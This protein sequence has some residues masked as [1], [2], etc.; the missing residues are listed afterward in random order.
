VYPAAKPRHDERRWRFPS[1]A[2]IWFTHCEREPD[3]GRFDGHEYQLIAFDE[4]THFTEKQYSTI[5]A[6]LRGPADLPKY[7]RGTTNPGGPGHDWVFRRW[8][9]WLNPESPVHAA[10][11]AKLWYMPGGDAGGWCEPGATST[12]HEG[13]VVRARSRVFIPARLD[14]NPFIGDEYRAELLSITD[15]VRRAQLLNGDWLIKP[16][17]GLYFKRGWFE[18]VD[19]APVEAQRVRYWDRAATPDGDWTVGLKMARTANKSLF[20]EDIV[21]FRGRPAEVLATIRQTAQLDGH[22]VAIGIEQDPG[23]AGVVEADLY[24]RELQG[25]N[26]RRVKPTGDKV[27][28]AQPASAQAEARNIK[29]VRGA[30]N[31]AFLQEVELFPTKGEPDD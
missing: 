25:F 10:P 4:L 14:D 28:R 26:I 11:S 30:W 15:P 9:P 19:A 12:D 23:Q 20:I 16:A 31:E 13:H 2:T 18:L 22:G 27:T 29:L 5:C 1:G 24:V 21:R 8:G 6:R 17:A 7:A 3:A